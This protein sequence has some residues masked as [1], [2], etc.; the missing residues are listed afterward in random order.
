MRRRLGASCL[1]LARWPCRRPWRLRRARYLRRLA[2]RAGSCSRRR[3]PR[4]G[5]FRW[6]AARSRPPRR[7]FVPLMCRP[8]LERRHWDLGGWRFARLE[9]LLGLLVLVVGSPGLDRLLR[10]VGAVGVGPT[11][12]LVSSLSFGPLARFARRI[13]AALR[14]ETVGRRFGPVGLR[15]TPAARSRRLIDLV[16]PA[17]LVD[18]G[19]ARWF[20]GLRGSSRVLSDDRV[21]RVELCGN[22]EKLLSLFYF[23]SAFGIG[24]LVA[25][26]PCWKF[27]WAMLRASRWRPR[28]SVASV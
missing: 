25:A 23:S 24:F 16:A 9:P 18:R 6:P 26:R 5:R 7:R 1:R 8:G 19:V 21:V 10:A 15:R 3:S 12:V 11:V 14:L 13:L 2:E 20:R 27:A 28:S 22:I 4:L 17:G